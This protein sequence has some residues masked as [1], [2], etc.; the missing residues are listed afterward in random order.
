MKQDMCF[1]LE[2]GSVSECIGMW[3]LVRE[4]LKCNGECACVD[5]CSTVGTLC[6]S[7]ECHDAFDCCHTYVT[8][9]AH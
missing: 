4:D 9:T 3:S 6:S 5:G 7:C 2:K 1:I 8:P